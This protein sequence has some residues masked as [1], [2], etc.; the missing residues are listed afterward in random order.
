MTEIERKLL[1]TYPNQRWQKV[2]VNTTWNLNPY[3]LCILAAMVKNDVKVKIIDAHFYNMSLEEFEKQ[4][5]EY[6]PDYV[7]ISVMTTEYADVLDITAN[8]VKKINPDIIVVAGGVHVTMEYENVMK[9]PNI[10]YAVRGEG[11]YVLQQLIVYLNGN[12]GFPAEGVVFRNKGTI[13]AF[14]WTVVGDISKLPWPEY[15]LIKLENYLNTGP[16]HG[17]LRPPAYPY[18]RMSVTR[19]CPFGCSFCQVAA[20]SGRKVRA[21]DPEDV[22]NEM[23]F[24]KEKYGIKSIL[25][26]DDNIIMD[27]TFLR[28][29]LE[30]MIE[31]QVNLKY[32][33]GAFAVFLMTEEIL[34]LLVKS[35]CVGL[36]VAIESG[37]KRVLKEIVHKP[38]D[39]EKA[40]IMIGKIREKGLFCIA[41]FIIGF[42]GERWEE[43]R[44]TVRYA[45]NCGADYIKIF[46]AVPLRGTRL[47]DKVV[48]IGAIESSAKVDW[49]H[50]QISS[51]EWTAKD[52]SILRVYEWDR[53]NFASPE[54]R[55][56]VAEIWGMNE[57]EIEKIRKET[58]DLLSV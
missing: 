19:G 32:I 34:E 36:N 43:I 38:V 46:I 55:K 18:I 23:L 28:R 56:R 15:N 7:G 12:G 33:I 49:R 50:G 29:L 58:R 1:L 45:E 51:N 48:E 39:L 25:F 11:E 22:V 41:N 9:N 8:A 2:D 4:V 30:L 27:R 14:P 26:D 47:W 20:I 16:R 37:N 13:E 35:G 31:K 57:E 40:R 54:K 52:V 53:I 3:T 21:R 17:P 5:E 24:L 6:G 10:D 44:E 42:P